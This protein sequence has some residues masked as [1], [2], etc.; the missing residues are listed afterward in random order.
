[1]GM[2]VLVTGSH[3]FIGR[4]VARAYAK[5]GFTVT[6]IG[7]GSWDSEEYSQFGI[8]FWH[9]V[10]VTLEALVTYAD[11]PDIIIHCAGS[12]S[13]AFSMS[14][15]YQDFVR[16]VSNTAAVLEYVRLHSPKTAVVYPSSAAIYGAVDKVPILESDPTRPASAYGTHKAMAEDLCRSYAR[17]FGVATV[18]V[19]FFSIYG[20]GLRK[21]LLWDACRKLTRQDFTFHGTGQEVRD[22]LHVEDAAS[23]LMCAA[24]TASVSC[25]VVNGGNGVGVTNAELLGIVRRSLAIPGEIGFN[26]VGRSGDPSRYVA[27]IRQAASL[28]WNPMI[29]LEDGVQDY[30][31]W[32]KSLPQA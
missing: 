5:A 2:N 3:G 18:I 1:M 27:E 24:T 9:A 26:G 19:R 28:G 4:H 22:W 23:L 7:H 20:A 11:K 12:G 31:S 14:Q 8:T 10:D 16:T 21:Q 25:P 6:G 17:H 32:F 29:A 15:P 13:V 30:V